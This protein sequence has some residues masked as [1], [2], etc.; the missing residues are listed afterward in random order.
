MGVTLGTALL[1][2]AQGLGVLLTVTAMYTITLLRGQGV[3]EARALAFT[4]LVIGNLSL[5]LA[6]HS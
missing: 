3:N 2:L 4:T 1:A 5:I 6:N